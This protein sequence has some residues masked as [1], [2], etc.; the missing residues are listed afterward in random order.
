MKV[1]DTS[2]QNCPAPLIETKRALKGMKEGE[3]CQ[4]ITDN[5]SSFNNI[6]RFLKD[7]STEFTTNESSG[8][9]VITIKK[10]AVD[11]SHAI[12]EDYCEKE[13]PHLLKGNFIVAI[14]SDKMGDGENELGHLLMV[15]FMKAL[16]DLERLPV[17]MLFYNSGVRLGS[18]NSEVADHLC[19][20]EKMGVELLFCETCVN[21][22]LLHGKM[23][24]GRLSNMFEIAQ[25]MASG[26]NILKP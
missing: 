13:I 17:R 14:G 11:V 19:E 16:K 6:S 15:N 2:G 22:Y 21:Y 1:I 20:I 3:S 24:A 7:N 12:S 8:K 23:K 4:I 18:E 26:L 10:G 5:K 25:I 9:W